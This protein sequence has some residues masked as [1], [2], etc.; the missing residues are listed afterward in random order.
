MTPGA[1]STTAD[2]ISTIA[3]LQKLTANA[4]H[5]ETKTK[6]RSSMSTLLGIVGE[7][8][9]EIQLQL[10]LVGQLQEHDPRNAYVEIG[11]Q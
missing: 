5:P 7:P 9:G 10:N 1:N 2:P 6:E 4:K 3:G 8:H 11:K